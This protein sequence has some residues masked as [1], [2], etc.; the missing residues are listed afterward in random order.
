M[1]K[2][3]VLTESKSL[4]GVEISHRDYAAIMRCIEFHSEIKE[5]IADRDFETF[6]NDRI[7]SLA[8]LN[9]CKVFSAI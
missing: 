4:S 6:V 1:N 7:V 8:V 2:N 9:L 3:L 5:L